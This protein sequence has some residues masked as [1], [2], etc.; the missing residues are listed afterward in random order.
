MLRAIFTMI[1]VRGI[2][3]F[4]PLISIPLIIKLLG[5]SGYGNYMVIFA[6][7][8]LYATCV[9]YG[10]DYTASRDISRTNN[11][12]ELN[13]LFSV[14]INCKLII[15]VA[16]S[17]FSFGIFLFRD[18]GVLSYIGILIFIFSQVLTPIYLF[19][20]MRK[21]SYLIYNTI[22]LNICNV[23]SIIVLI[24]FNSSVSFSELFLCDN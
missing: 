20:G 1:I 17:L 12:S 9:N 5:L 19:Q 8:S 13:R 23:A 11:S 14:F 16:T 7:S 2:T 3:L 15:F 21:M 4:F 10:F 18:D 22:F 6:L 24:I